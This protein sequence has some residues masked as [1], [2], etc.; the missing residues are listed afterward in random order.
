[1]TFIFSAY[2]DF[3][4][5]LFKT[6]QVKVFVPNYFIFYEVIIKLMI[7]VDFDKFS[8][9]FAKFSFSFYNPCSSSDPD[10][11]SIP[12]DNSCC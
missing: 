6:A 8:V 2:F 9:A 11:K 1:M 10:M 3:G 12:Y 5:Q 4:R 7:L